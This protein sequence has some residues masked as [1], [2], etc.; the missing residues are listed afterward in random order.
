MS[1]RTRM[2]LG[3]L[4]LG[5]LSA[6]GCSPAADADVSPA[7]GAPLL[8]APENIVVVDT[9]ELRSGPA[10]SGTLEARR[11]ATI[12]AEIGGAVLAV[13]VEEGQAVAAGTPLVR[14]DAATLREQFRSAESAVRVAAEQ[15]ELA[16]RNLAR[17]ERLAAAGALA[18]QSAE[19]ARAAVLAAEA[20]LADAEARRTA[21]GTLLGKAEA[22]APFA[23]IVSARPVSLG[24][25]VQPGTPLVTVVDPASMELG[26]AV[27]VGALEALRRGSQVDFTVPGYEGRRFTGSVE[28]INPAVD[29]LT[30]QVRITV[31][32][33]NPDGNLVAGLFAQGRVA[34]AA[35]RNLAVPFSALDLR[36][37]APVLTVLR[38]GRIAAVTPRLGIRDEAQELVEVL[39]GLVAGDTVL[40][41]ATRGLAPT[42]AVRVGRD[43]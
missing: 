27:P 14:L 1:S 10:I 28:R 6:A 21:A 43:Q 34:T 19:Q 41:G 38:Q 8:I 42:T 39:E 18:D 20:S 7:D 9:M 5:T 24:D 2:I 23:G 3:L 15:A 25:I 13:L 4:A 29:P 16:R 30:R 35:S 37:T 31:T 12:R 40:I 11:N 17:S 33:P 36:G 26:A 32:I 22:R